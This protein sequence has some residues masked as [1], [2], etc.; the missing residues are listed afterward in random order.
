MIII[1]FERTKLNLSKLLENK[2]I[3]KHSYEQNF[4]NELCS[5][6]WFK[7]CNLNYLFIIINL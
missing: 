2:N 7:C 4:F 1:K 3:I 6:I 5:F